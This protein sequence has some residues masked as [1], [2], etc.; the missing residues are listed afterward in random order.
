MS[1]L[2]YSMVTSL[3]GFIAGPD[4]GFDWSAPD[5]ELH[6]FHNDQ[7]RQVSLQ[8]YG[9]RL[10]ETMLFWETA[11]ERPGVDPVELE[12]QEI[13]KATPKVVFSRTL[14]AVEG[15]QTRLA[16]G[17]DAGD[18][19]AR[20]KAQAGDGQVAIGGAGL[21]ATALQRGL[22]DELH[23][24]LA[25]VVVGGGTPFFPPL[26]RLIRFEL[27]ATRTFGGGVQYLRYVAGG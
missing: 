25:P 22:V 1:T 14:T 9:R 12:F 27:A 16:S 3:D 8:L 4:G 5:E 10:Y 21:A 26:E 11:H 15:S 2:I 23:L 7:A 17:D 18:E 6:R 19:I 24:I 20:L 13:W